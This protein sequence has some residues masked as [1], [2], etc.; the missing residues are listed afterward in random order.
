MSDLNELM[1]EKQDWK[2]SFAE[3]TE[4]E[5]I[6]DSWG[7]CAK[8]SLPVRATLALVFDMLVVQKVARTLPGGKPANNILQIV[9]DYHRTKKNILAITDYEAATKN[10]GAYLQ[11]ADHNMGII[12]LVV[13]KRRLRQ[14]LPPI[15]DSGHIRRLAKVHNL[16]ALSTLLPC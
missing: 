1:R 13:S 12:S 11:Y 15:Q 5:S 10:Y 7:Q 6:Y 16:V 3:M 2:K 9:S 4:L 14:Y 8:E